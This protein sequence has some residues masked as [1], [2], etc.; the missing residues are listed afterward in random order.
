MLSIVIVSYNVIHFLEACLYSLRQA[1]QDIEH[2]IFVVDNHSADGSAK[3]VEQLFPDVKLIAN[4]QNVGFSKAN[5]QAIKRCKG[6]Y[7]LLLNPD[8]IVKPDALIK[9]IQFMEAHPEAGGLGIKMLDGTGAYLPESKRGLPTPWVSFYKIFG[10]GKLFPKS[11]KY[12]RYYLSHL[13]EEKVQEIEILSGAYMFLRREALNKSGLLD[14]S[15]FMYG[16]DVD[17]SYRLILAGYKNYYLP[18]AEI[19]HFKG[20]STKRGSFNYVNQFYKA[21]A[22]FAQKHFASPNSFLFNQL[23]YIGI[24]LRGALSLLRRFIE[25]ILPATIDF[26]II[27]LLMLYAVNWW[28][29]NFKHEPGMYPEKFTEIILPI[30]V[31][32]WVATVKVI[33]RYSRVVNLSTII[34][35]VVVGTLII[36]AITNFFDAYRFSKGLIIIGA[37]LSSGVLYLTRLIPH[38]FRTGNLELGENRFQ[39][40]L[41]VGNANDYAQVLK[42]LK[43]SGKNAKIFGFVSADGNDAIGNAGFLGQI[44][45]VMSIIKQYEITEI[46][47]SLN[48]PAS[49]D[50]I[51]MMQQLSK[52]N[53]GFRFTVPG[54]DYIIGSSSKYNQG[55]FYTINE[56]PS[57]YLHHNLRMKRLADIGLTILLLLFTPLIILFKP[58]TIH[59]W[60]NIWR[61]MNGK[62]TWVGPTHKSNDILPDSVI[63][64]SEVPSHKPEIFRKKM[65]EMYL[66]H[67]NPLM[68][69]KIFF[70]GVFSSSALQK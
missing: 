4:K 55:D 54:S 7:I 31:M 30:Y 25:S 36:S 12:G 56:V 29:I 37:A 3:M 48:L 9:C 58:Q 64:V 18:D 26:T 46:V 61:V 67:Y 53:I 17:L 23:I 15:F 33:G 21:M 14:E 41:V 40:I 66:W 65:E 59:L 11:E 39:H 35:G 32:V 70:Q 43:V 13:S 62:L 42:I 63:K 44:S 60:R 24:A 28:E 6:K 10:L 69:F 68:D 27:Y 16:E 5:N 19:I 1:L 34:K 38:Y 50:F 57:L 8:T 47:F 45:E 49:V 51:G 22:I 20:E 2:E 52:Q